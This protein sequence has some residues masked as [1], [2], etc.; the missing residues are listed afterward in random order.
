M[1][2]RKEGIINLEDDVV[3]NN[4][5]ISIL[6]FD[7][8]AICVHY[9]ADKEH[10]RIYYKEVETEAEA[11]DYLLTLPQHSEATII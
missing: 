6:S 1:Q 3:I 7:E 10:A 4:A 5:T 11:W 2:Y 8:G 9:K